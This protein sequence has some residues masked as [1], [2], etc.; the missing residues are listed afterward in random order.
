MPVIC[1]SFLERVFIES[2]FTKTLPTGSV[3]AWEGR[4][5]LGVRSV[6]AA[7]SVNLS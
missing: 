1:I 2:Q 7:T 6:A 4:E 3:R 5:S